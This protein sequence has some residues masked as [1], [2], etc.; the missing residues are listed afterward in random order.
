M[1]IK[2]RRTELWWQWLERTQPLKARW[3]LRSVSQ[4]GVRATLLGKATVDG[5]D[6]VVGDD[7]KVWSGHRKTVISGWGRMR[8]GDRVFVNSGT[9]ILCVEQITVGNDVAFGNEVMVF[10]SDSHGVAGGDVRQA[11]V[12][13]GDGCWLGSRSMVLPGVTLGR[14]VLVAA[15]AVVTKDVPDDCLVAGNP[16]RVIR[17]LD[18][19]EGCLRAWHDDYCA[20]PT[21]GVFAAV[22]Q[23]LD[24]SVPEAVLD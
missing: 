22:T 1:S 23:L 18:Y 5:S 7:F 11:P 10:D 6:M 12:T 21:R 8:F 20:C 16:A 3:Q 14:R 15:G 19:P 2:R 24:E 13:I 9:I 4:V 17:T